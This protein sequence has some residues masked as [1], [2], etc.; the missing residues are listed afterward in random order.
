MLFSLNN[1]PK[2][3]S[4]CN[5]DMENEKQG[6]PLTLYSF[7]GH[8]F[9]SVY[10]SAFSETVESSNDPNCNLLG[11]VLSDWNNPVMIGIATKTKYLHGNMQGKFEI[12]S[13]VIWIFPMT[14]PGLQKKWLP[15]DRKP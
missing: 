5:S 12:L 11:I 3:L 7:I 6:I 1:A 13:C 10:P 15:E 2:I 8:S 4:D 14:S 9:H